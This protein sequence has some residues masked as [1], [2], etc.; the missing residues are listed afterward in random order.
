MKKDQIKKD[1]RKLF[2]SMDFISENFLNREDLSE[3]E[4]Q[5]YFDIYQQ[6]G[7]A[8]E[9][10]G[11]QCRHRKGYRRI[12]DGKMACKIC[13]KIKD[14]DDLYYLLPKKGYKKIGIKLKPNSKRTFK[15]KQDAQI[16][17][18]TINFHGALIDVDVFNSYK[19]SITGCEINIAEDRIVR[20]KEDGIECSI[21]RHL[22][23]I[24]MNKTEKKKLGKIYGGFPW[25]IQKKNLKKFP[26]IFDFDEDYRFLGLRILR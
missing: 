23:N 21:D 19:S 16:D 6:L 14:T 9:F 2:K 18:D 25:E 20:L 24:E 15:N 26:V 8:W 4:L 10:L 17:Y 5:K 1:L 3:K 22:V 12:K 7:I 13:G 11:L